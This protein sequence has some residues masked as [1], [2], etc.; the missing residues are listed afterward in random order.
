MKRVQ[1]VFGFSF[2]VLAI[3]VGLGQ[4][5]GPALTSDLFK[6]LQFRSLGP[7]L[8]TGRVAD[9][10]VDP[11]NPSV[12]YVAAAAGGLWKT[13]NRGQTFKPIFDDGGSFNLSCVVIDP[14]DSNVL[15]LGT[16]ENSNP[17]SAMYGDGLYK[18]TD[19]GATWTRVGL[20]GSEHIGNIKI[21]PRNSNVVYVAAQG[22]L[23]NSGGDRGLYKT[24][25]GGKTW[26]MILPAQSM[27]DTGANE[28][29]IDPLNPD[30]LYASLYQRRRSI[31]QF[32]GG[33]PEG[34]IYKSLNAG[35]TWTKL[36]KGLPD[37]VGRIAL[38]TDPKVKPT[39]VYALIDAVG[40]EQGFYR[41]DDAGASWTRMGQPTG[42]DAAPAGGAAPA[43]AAPANAA[44]GGAARGGGARGGA[45]GGA[46][47][48]ATGGAATGGAAAGGAQAGGAG[49]GGGRPGGP[50]G[51]GGFGGGANPAGQDPHYY[52]EIFVDPTRPDTVWGEGLNM[53]RTDDG[54]KAWHAVT[55]Q[56]N[57]AIH[58]DFHA[59]AFDLTDKNH[60]IFGNDGG[61][62]ETWD[63]G[64]NVRHF[65]NLPISQFYRIAVDNAL[66][67]YHVCGGLQDNNSMCGPSRSINAYGIR[68]G[69][70]YLVGGGDG[71]QPR[72]DPEDPNTVY[73]TSQ[74][75]GLGRLDLR[76]SQS[77]SIRPNTF[78][79][80]DA[81][82]QPVGAPAAGGRGGGGGGRGG[83]ERVNWDC[84]YMISPHSHT[85]LYIGGEKVYRS[86]DRGDSW[87]PISP[88]L[89]RDLDPRVIPIMGKVWDPLTTVSYNRST[90]QLSTIVSIDESLLLEGLIYVGTDDGLVQVTED[91]G[92]NWRKTDKFPG[93][94]DGAYVSDVWASAR[95]A[96]VVFITI[97]NHQ[98]GDFKPYVLRSDDRGKTFTSITGDLPASRNNLWS[99]AR[100]SAVRGRRVRSVLHGRWRPS[101]D[102]D[103]E[104]PADHAGARHPY[105]E[106]RKRSR[107]RH[108]RPRDLRAGRLQCAPRGDAGHD[109]RRGAA[110]ADP[111][112][113]RLQRVPSRAGLDADGADTE[114][115]GGRAH[116]LLRLGG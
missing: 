19:A 77:K 82:T 95:D 16:G 116:Q 64:K 54:G 43:A 45:A 31:G 60:W 12:W 39:R 57:S 25:D 85:R 94:P 50:A 66:P 108:V 42:P 13:D 68:T 87:T 1:L 65:D 71:F 22:P 62:Y 38:G 26:K 28:I 70:W 109:R 29:Q 6:D 96:N 15:W 46:A 103:E 4:G 90:T 97:G 59:I 105:P 14:K 56:Y 104:R 84:A 76:T 100:Q 83:T 111:H 112:D 74:F 20:E 53:Y 17:R 40:A 91:G 32:I 36:T 30:I 11:K 92:K 48:G 113:V 102:A 61:L 18:S 49:A 35:A 110:A 78:S 3:A 55:M 58:V 5:T 7:S 115:S 98:H 89:T 2:T 99:V 114:S 9:V 86:D 8:T 63:E 80:G 52:Y 21:D 41:S 73:A 69:D 81:P 93:A 34:G 33:G 47:A 23:W 75:C 72:I 37:N 107:D 24:M 88:N 10:A 101:L 79:A 27:P 44:R 106:A 67:F 51:G